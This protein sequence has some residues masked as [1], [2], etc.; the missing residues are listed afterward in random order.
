MLDCRTPLFVTALC[1]IVEVREKETPAQLGT[2][3]T[4]K[5]R[6]Q[7]DI[8]AHETMRRSDMNARTENKKPKGIS[9]AKDLK[10]QRRRAEC[11]A[12]LSQK[13]PH[14]NDE[15]PDPQGACAPETTVQGSE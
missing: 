4:P 3:P 12:S 7:T 1:F 15:P 13:L 5:R 2:L 9:K 6:F 14:G 8:G 11:E 10:N